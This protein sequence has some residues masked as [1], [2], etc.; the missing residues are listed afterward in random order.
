MAKM[1]GLKI[2]VRDKLVRDMLGRIR[3]QV[4]EAGKQET[5]KISE[6]FAKSMKDTILAKF[7]DL[8]WHG[9]LYDSIEVAPSRNTRGQFQSG[10]TVA[11][12]DYGFFI[13]KFEGFVSLGIPIVYEWFMDHFDE[14]AIGTG[15]KPGKK[16]YIY[17]ESHPWIYESISSAATEFRKYDLPQLKKALE[18]RR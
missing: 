4:P 14:D 7:P 16:G 18:G 1:I 2:K 9:A 3:T 11:L 5:K 8:F 12:N 6:I 15:H 13:D 17:V 10:F